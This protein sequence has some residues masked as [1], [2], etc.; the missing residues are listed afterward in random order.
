MKMYIDLVSLPKGGFAI[1][2]EASALKQRDPRQQAIY[3]LRQ[4]LEWWRFYGTDDL[5]T[6]KSGPQAIAFPRVFCSQC[7]FWEKAEAEFQ[8][9]DIALWGHCHRKAP[10][11]YMEPE[12]P[13]PN[14]EVRWPI[15]YEGEWCSEGEPKPGPKTTPGGQS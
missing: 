3:M 2:A 9:P 5:P 8:T 4:M 15:V 7:R 6:E 1:L 12:N 14:V 10:A 11:P 13:A